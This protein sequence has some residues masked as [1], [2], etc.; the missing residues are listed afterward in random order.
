MLNVIVSFAV[1][2]YVVFKQV[3]TFDSKRCDPKTDSQFLAMERVLMEPLWIF[4]CPVL[5]IL[6]VHIL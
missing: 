5:I 1:R 4:R 2:T 3:R 6:F